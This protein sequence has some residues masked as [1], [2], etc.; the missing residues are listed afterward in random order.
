MRARM[1]MRVPPTT[2][3]PEVC[4]CC[5]SLSLGRKHAGDRKGT[6][7]PLNSG[8]RHSRIFIGTLGC[9]LLLMGLATFVLYPRGATFKIESFDINAENTTFYEG[10]QL[11]TNWISDVK[12]ANHNFFPLNIHEMRLSLFLKKDRSA[13]IGKGRGSLLYVS[14]RSVGTE[15]IEFQ[16]PV[17]AP[18]SSKPSLISECMLN[19]R[20]DLLVMAQIDLSWTHW[21]GR[22]LPLSFIITVDCRIPAL[23]EAITLAH[24]D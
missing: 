7:C 10:D 21:S 3:V 12:I 23:K 18:S 24:L 4:S 1:P 8:S 17:Y 5:R 13:P 11:M 22:W 14:S 19:D 16:M 2:F 6:D 20:V 9:I 15:S